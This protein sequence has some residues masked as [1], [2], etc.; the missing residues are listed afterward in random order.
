LLAAVGQKI[1]RVSAHT[2]SLQ[3]HLPPV[4]TV[5]AVLGTDQGRSGTYVSSVGIKAKRAMEFE[6]V[7]NKGSVIYRPFQ[8]E[9]A[10]KQ[11]E[12][13]SEWVERS[14]RAPLMWGVKEEVAA[15]ADGRDIGY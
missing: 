12:G 11:D 10:I 7:T 14:E 8:M 15:F 9:I 13:G 3:A 1:S 2:T 6:V 5:H 4:D